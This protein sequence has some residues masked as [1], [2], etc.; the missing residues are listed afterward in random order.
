MNR[1]RGP[2]QRKPDVEVR[3]QLFLLRLLSN[4]Q[5][6]GTLFILCSG[7][8]GFGSYQMLVSQQTNLSC[9]NVFWPFASASLRLYCAQKRAEKNTLEDLFAAIG[10]VD[11]LDQNHPLRSAIDPQIEIWSNRALDLAEKAFHEGKLDRAISFAKRIPARTTAAKVVQ[12]RIKRWQ[13]VWAEGESIYKKA[14]DTL[15]QE[16]WRQAFSIMVGLL[17]VDNRYWSGPQ[18][19]ALNKR[20]LRAQEDEKIIAKAKSLIKRGGLRNLAEAIGLAQDLKSGSVFQRSA[21]VAIEDA[22]QRLMQ[23]AENALE[24]Q[25]LTLALDAAQLIPQETRVGQRAKDFVDLAYAAASAWSGTAAGLQDAI[26]AARKISSNSSVYN[27]AQDL[28][29]RWE[30]Q[31]ASLR[32]RQIAQANAD[33]YNASI[34]ESIPNT[35]DW[36]DPPPALNTASKQ[37]TAD[38]TLLDRADS[39]SLNGD[40]NSLAEAI[41]IAKQI[42]PS[43]VFYEDAQ[44]R[45]AD[46]QF[47]LQQL[48]NPQSIEK[49]P[50]SLDNNVPDNAAKEL[51]Q[52]AKGYASQG[53]PGSLATA[54]D[55]ANQIDLNSPLR[56]Q[57]EESVSA[58]SQKILTIARTQA[59][60]NISKA[61]AI[62]RQIPASSPVY[63]DAQSQIQ[64]WQGRS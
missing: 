55:V 8:L 49:L 3:S 13:T 62:A 32:Q 38:L 12:E 9:R 18:Y 51:W 61:I 7:L 19:N 56:V 17:K 28:A 52:Q 15:N 64:Q 58:W 53:S 43:R 44:A 34:V 10:L 39:L 33:E 42:A 41:R 16:N 24:R 4:W 50:E 14:E 35:T 63:N 59:N 31:L 57:A 45:I 26:S 48:N 2:L 25:D 22:S 27:Q 46:W 6:C 1:K 20:I 21:S 29:L 23:L 60:S 47:Q 37:Q 30:G 11:V 5:A 36:Q 54:I 40:R